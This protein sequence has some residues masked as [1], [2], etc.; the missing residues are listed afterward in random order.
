MDVALVTHPPA[1][2]HSCVG[3]FGCTSGVSLPTCCAVAVAAA[4]NRRAAA[5]EKRAV[6]VTVDN[7]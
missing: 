5:V 7:E 2:V 1:T 3:N 4:A 6:M